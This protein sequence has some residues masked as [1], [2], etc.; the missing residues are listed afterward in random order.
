MEYNHNGLGLGDG[1]PSGGNN[2][3]EY[4]H[5]DPMDNYQRND[6]NEYQRQEEK[7]LLPFMMPFYFLSEKA[8]IYYHVYKEYT[9]ALERIFKERV[10]TN[11]SAITGITEAKVDKFLFAAVKRYQRGALIVFILSF[12]LSIVSVLTSSI[13][14]VSILSTL[15]LIYVITS[16]IYIDLWYPSKHYTHASKKFADE[17]LTITQ[18]FY[19]NYILNFSLTEKVYHSSLIISWCVIILTFLLK[20]TIEFYIKFDTGIATSFSWYLL[21]VLMIIPSSFLMLYYFEKQKTINQA[22]IKRED[23]IEAISNTTKTNFD[24]AREKLKNYK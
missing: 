16:S 1:L 20:D 15:F 13:F 17:R 6:H 3:N 9:S 14:L 11:N 10:F 2:I 18:E 5:N 8:G 4:N 7:Q 24:I 12:V 22:D 21:V 23:L 19:N